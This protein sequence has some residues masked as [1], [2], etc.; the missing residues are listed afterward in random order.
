MA[1]LFAATH[2]DRVSALVL[3]AAFARA[4]WAPG[5]EWTWTAEERDARMEE[6]VDHWG[7][8][9]VPAGVA[10]SRMDDPEFMEWAGRLERL[11]GEPGD[12]QAHLRP[13]R[14][15]RRARRAPIDPRP[16][17]R[18]APA[19]GH[20][21]Q[22]RALP[23]P[24]R[25]HPRRALRRARGRRQHVLDRRQRGAAR[26]DRGVPDRRAPRARARP[27]ARHR[28]VHR[29]LR[30][31][32][33]RRADGR[34]LLALH[35]R[36]PRRAVPARPR[37]A[38]AAGRSSTPATASSPPSTDPRGRSA[39]PPTTRPRSPRSACRCAPGCTPAS[40][41]SGT[42]TWAAW[43]CTSRARV[44]DQADPS[45][46]LVSSTVKDLVVGSGI[47]FAERGSHELRGVPGE[48]SLFSVS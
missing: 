37:A 2:P 42:A 34:P 5:Y 28:A 35:A 41:R 46:V 26:R 20:V 25:A 11:V 6:L 47:E 3:Y 4:T 38:T 23:L 39:A 12:D 10:P 8:G 36:A 19:R 29:H 43:R 31:H 45:E 18:H 7:E 48:W 22:G 15:V 32:R 44:L 40:S 16:D 33:A 9:W 27:D 1:A 14:R 13:D 21:H 17:A 24:G 30:L